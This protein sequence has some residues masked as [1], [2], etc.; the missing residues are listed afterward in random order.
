MPIS[1]DAYMVNNNNNDEPVCGVVD[2]SPLL[3][4]SA[5]APAFDSGDGGS[6]VVDDRLRRVKVRNTALFLLCLK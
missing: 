5:E 2:P 6:L 4:V 3:A 1:K